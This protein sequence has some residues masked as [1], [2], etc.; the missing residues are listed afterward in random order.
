MVG[1]PPQSE[2]AELVLSTA[3]DADPQFAVAALKLI[4]HVGIEVFRRK[5]TD[6]LPVLPV[7]LLD[8]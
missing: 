4:K 8:E 7:D 1:L 6:L 2:A 3:L 5:C